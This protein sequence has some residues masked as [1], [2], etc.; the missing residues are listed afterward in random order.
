MSVFS[1]KI[2]VAEGGKKN[3]WFSMVFLRDV[4]GSCP[5][6]I[7]NDELR[8]WN[9]ASLW[10]IDPEK[11][12]GCNESD[13]IRGKSWFLKYQDVF[14]EVVNF[15]WINLWNRK[16]RG[17]TKKQLIVLKMYER[18][19]FCLRAKTENLD[20]ERLRHKFIFFS[21]FSWKE[22]AEICRFPGLS[23]S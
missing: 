11:S 21:E 13:Y 22:L 6:R 19:C 9:L 15:L 16:M 7:V 3:S 18:N 10:Q 14:T 8:L 20:F 17:K 4:I 12:M 23:F 5:N 2:H 1:G